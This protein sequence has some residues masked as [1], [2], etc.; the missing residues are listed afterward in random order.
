HSEFAPISSM[1]DER[2]LP[3]SV[4]RAALYPL[5]WTVNPQAVA[6]HPF[7]DWRFATVY[8]LLAVLGIR[9]SIRRWGQGWR[10]GCLPSG[11]TAFL[12]AGVLASY[13]LWLW[14][15][16]YYRY[17]APL[18]WLVPL[19]ITLALWTL[20]PGRHR[21]FAIVAVLFLTTV[22]TRPMNWGRASWA[23]SYFG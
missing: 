19:G 3:R 2:F 14:M 10:P 1:R 13:A 12:L 6:E 18:E 22:T 7:R 20:L 8:C 23:G 4:I 15:F 17:L 11:P 21:T 9:W 16:G 5:V